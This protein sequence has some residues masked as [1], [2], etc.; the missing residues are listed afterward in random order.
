MILFIV[1]FL[2]LSSAYALEFLYSP[3]V[4][5][6]ENV[7]EFQ[8]YRKD[9]PPEIVFEEGDQ[10][11]SCKWLG[12]KCP[13]PRLTLFLPGKLRPEKV[14]VTLIRNKR[15]RNLEIRLFPSGFPFPRIS[16][17]SS[18]KDP[19]I[20]SVFRPTDLPGSKKECHLLILS[21][22]NE[23][24][25]YR[26]LP[27]PCTD[28]RPHQIGK[29]T[30]YSYAEIEEG[31]D[32]LGYFGPRIIL[33]PDFS[34]N[35]KICLNCSTQEFLLWDLNHWM[36]IEYE[37]S[38]LQGGRAYM[39]K[40]IREIKN[41]KVI[42]EW[43]VSDYL[44]Q[45]RSEATT[46]AKLTV[47]RG[48]VIVHALH[49]NSVQPIGD[50]GLVIGLG[51]NGVAYLNKKT[52]QVEWS[53]A[54]INDEFALTSEQFPANQDSAYFEVGVQ[55]LHLFINHSYHR[56]SQFSKIATYDLNLKQKKVLAF[57]IVRS[58]EELTYVMGSLQLKR[59]VYSLTFGER[60]RGD[61]DFVE[62]AQRKDVWMLRFGDSW[63]VTRAYRGPSEYL[64]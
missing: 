44:Q 57:E 49:I 28:F 15:K 53:F 43:G 19:L 25:F 6:Q 17:E 31:D 16:G 3:V 20:L 24:N 60:T 27:V 58:K 14:F 59:G 23:L 1:T 63:R 32:F 40:K 21:P 5:V 2:T 36:G 13:G 46:K 39:N 45:F 29:E 11:V 47:F 61:W 52:R 42:F 26:L 54:G 50:R 8:E 9:R 38:R 7:Y 55:R 62:M 22:K 33:N 4:E 30:Y 34:L 35:K 56:L 12:K 10:I 51:Y 48:E 41:D 64:Q 37:I 18:L